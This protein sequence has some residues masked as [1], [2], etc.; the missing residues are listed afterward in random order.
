MLAPPLFGKFGKSF[1]DLVKKKYD[2]KNS[3]TLK[4]KVEN[5]TLETG[6]TVGDS[7]LVGTV[8][9]VGTHGFGETETNI[10]TDG[11]VLEFKAKHTKLGQGL[12]VHLTANGVK[13]CG[14][15][16]AEYQHDFVSASASVDATLELD[17]KFNG[18]VVL[19]HDRL[20]VGLGGTYGTKYSNFEDYNAGVEYSTKD[21]TAT[22]QTKRRAELL[23][24]S[25]FH[26]V[27]H[28]TPGLKT[29]VGAQLDV[30]LASPSTNY[31]LTIAAEHQL[32]KDMSVKAKVDTAGTVA[33]VV[34]HRMENPQFK[35]LVSAQW[36][37]AKKSSS[38][39]RFGVG[40]T[41]GDV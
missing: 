2:F 5:M 24:A 29:Q 21:F 23:A 36:N 35:L 16:L 28:R 34:E 38:P 15:L 10:V 25:Y 22:V 31:G 32:S 14:Q 3:L 33:T 27:T 19:S 39:D 20:A 40:V 9:A 1:S 12:T 8:K 11:S 30:T 7:G 37:L 26:N 6:A 4:D 18:S 13:S 41:V 17:T